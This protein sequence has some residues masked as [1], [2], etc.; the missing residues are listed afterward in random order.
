[1]LHEA[2]VALSDF[3]LAGLSGV[4]AGKLL[5]RNTERLRIRNWF[6]VAIGAIAVAALLGGMAHGFFPDTDSFLGALI[7]R[8]TLVCIGATGLAAVMIASFLL[9][10][11]G[12]VERVRFGVLIAFAIYCGIV[13]FEWQEFVV[14]LV[15]YVPAAVL[16]FVAFLIRWRREHDSFAS[17]GLIAMALTFL[18]AGMQYFR[19]G[20]DPI[21][22]NNNVIYHLVQ[23]AGVIYL[24]R[25]GK[26][27]MKNLE[28]SRA[29]IKAF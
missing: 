25:A 15:F 19:I 21:Y 24:Y 13:F 11:P 17:D 8:T 10:R 14:A 29:R 1:M 18:A 26:R 16:L 28:T 6:T 7:W 9:F 4:L 5:R 12:T 22:L 20:L 27:W 23:G 2:A 3:A